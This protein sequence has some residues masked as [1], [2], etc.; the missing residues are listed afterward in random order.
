MLAEFQY[1]KFYGLLLENNTFLLYGWN[2]KVT[3]FISM[4][5]K[6]RSVLIL[7]QKFSFWS[8][9]LK[10]WQWEIIWIYLSLILSSLAD[11]FEFEETFECLLFSLAYE[12]RCED[13]T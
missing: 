8:N 2:L 10:K 5:S 12:S 9:H 4:H 13:I 3:K 11:L 1:G 6:D 7:W